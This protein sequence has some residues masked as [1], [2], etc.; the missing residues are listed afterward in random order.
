MSWILRA[1]GGGVKGPC[2]IFFF[3]CF[4]FLQV[5]IN[6]PERNVWSDSRSISAALHH[7]SSMIAP[8]NPLVSRRALRLLCSTTSFR[9]S[10][11]SLIHPSSFDPS[12][13]THLPSI[14]FF[15]VPPLLVANLFLMR[16]VS[17]SLLPAPAPPSITVAPD[18]ETHAKS[19]R[20]RCHRCLG[21]LRRVRASENQSQ[22]FSLSGPHWL[23]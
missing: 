5:H 14:Q 21:C 2:W 4:V 1:E 6:A 17:R 13:P 8:S 9:V 11:H 19:P 3:F 23:G 10:F 18:S 22:D 20:S 12:F 15:F 7:C 16:L